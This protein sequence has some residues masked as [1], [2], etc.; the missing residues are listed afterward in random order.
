MSKVLD[1]VGHPGVG[2]DPETLASYV[3][4]SS[5]EA[6]PHQVLLIFHFPE[7]SY[8]IPVVTL[9]EEKGPC[10]HALITFRLE[11]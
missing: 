2:L 5:V 3:L 8:Y 7:R 6:Q 10:I 4:G 1:V 9:S 11:Y